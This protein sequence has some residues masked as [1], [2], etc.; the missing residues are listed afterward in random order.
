M[1]KAKIKEEVSQN[2]VTAI[3]EMED[4]GRIKNVSQ[5]LSS[6]QLNQSTF[7]KI[8][9]GEGNYVTLDLIYHAVN[10]LGMNAN[11]VFAKDGLNQESLLREQV[12]SPTVNGNNNTVVGLHGKL[13]ING[14]SGAIGDITVAEKVINQIENK[15]QKAELK[16]HMRQVASDI[17]ALKKMLDNYKKQIDDKDKEIATKNT[18]IET[19]VEL[20]KMFK[21]DN[22]KKK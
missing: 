5:F 16:R 1:E 19:Q 10:T 13:N 6:L 17:E 21:K 7:S 18:L 9:K 2:F 4:Q 8:K 3:Q 20:I 22:E 14:N 12:N 15:Q 11:H